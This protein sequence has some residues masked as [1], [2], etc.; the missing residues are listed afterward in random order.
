MDNKISSYTAANVLPV[1]VLKRRVLDRE[2]R[3]I[4]YHIQLNPTNHCNLKCEFCSC[5]NRDKHLEIDFLDIKEIMLNARDCGCKAVT[6][7]GGGEPLLYH[8]INQLIYFLWSFRIKIGLVTNGTQF[9]RLSPDSLERITWIRVSHSDERPFTDEYARELSV[10]MNLENQVDWAFSYVLSK[11]PNFK[12]I[13]S[14]IRF[15]NM[16]TSMTHVRIVSDLL[17][18][19]H[20]PN[21]LAVK[22]YLKRAGISDHLVIYQG[23]KKFVRGRKKCLISLLKPV[24]GA[25]SN[26]YPCCGSQYAKDPPAGDYDESM[27]MGPASDLTEIYETQRYFDGSQCVR[28]YYDEYNALLDQLTTPI[29]HEEFV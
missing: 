21:M 19:E 5:A 13:T 20:V 27:C 23:R 11:R 25:D 2:G 24:I 10:F 16:I 26:L 1:K 8:S 4:P 7:T 18:L 15:S 22:D 28:C 29:D 14:L 17:D 9:E 3:I 6:I 12:N